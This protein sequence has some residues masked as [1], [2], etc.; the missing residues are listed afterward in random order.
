VTTEQGALAADLSVCLLTHS[1]SNTVVP[2]W[3]WMSNSG[4]GSEGVR[5]IMCEADEFDLFKRF[6]RLLAS[7]AKDA[8]SWSLP[9]RRAYVPAHL[10]R[11]FVRLLFPP[12]YAPDEVISQLK[13]KLVRQMDGGKMKVRGRL[14]ELTSLKEEGARLVRQAR[15]DEAIEPF[16]SSVVCYLGLDEES[17]AKGAPLAA[18]C[19]LNIALCLLEARS[20][21]KASEVEVCCRAALDLLDEHGG[22]DNPALLAK[23]HYRMGMARELSGD[24]KGAAE[25]L[26]AALCCTPGNATIEAAMQRLQ[27]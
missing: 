23:A 14:E 21:A 2:W 15:H 6:V 7:R 10:H 12:L 22:A 17:V 1:I 3:M 16:Q 19:Y 8:S 13:E 4:A 9:P 20:P 26:S 25:A 27:L 18:Q 24:R 11:H 5:D